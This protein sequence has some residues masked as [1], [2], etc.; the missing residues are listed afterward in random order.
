MQNATQNQQYTVRIKHYIEARSHNDFYREKTISITYSECVLVA[1]VI[2][3]AERMHSIL[4]SSVACL[5][6]PYLST[7]SHKRHDFRTKKLL[8]LKCVLIFSTIFI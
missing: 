2:Q 5:A 4:L 7:L 3:H 1:L 8:N 6:V